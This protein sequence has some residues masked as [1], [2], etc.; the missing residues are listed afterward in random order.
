[1][2]VKEL[3]QEVRKGNRI[4]GHKLEELERLR[5]LCHVTGVNLEGERVSG[6]HNNSRVEQ[7]YLRYIAFKD[8]L[9]RYIANAMNSRDQLMALIDTLDN[10]QA[11]DIMYKYCL[12]N[13]PMLQIADIMGYTKQNV[14]KIYKNAIKTMQERVYKSWL[15]F[16]QID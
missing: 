7:S 8:D 11:I 3:I 14:Y 5:S 12:F 2:D 16:T 15:N 1:M 4:V 13:M 10:Q 6:S 9:E